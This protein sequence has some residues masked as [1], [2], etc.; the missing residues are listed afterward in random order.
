MKSPKPPDPYQTAQAQFGG[1]V[2]AAQTSSIMNNPDVYNFYGQQTWTPGAT[3]YVTG[4]NG[5]RI[6][7]TRQ[8]QRQTLSPAEQQ[9]AL[10]EQRARG[11]LSNTAAEQA[12]VLQKDLRNKIDPSK[13]VS[14]DKGPR[15]EEVR[16]DQGPTD[17]PAIEDAMMKL[18]HRQ[19]DP[20]AE[21]QMAQ[22][23]ARGA[24][25]GTPIANQAQQ[26]QNDAQTDAILKAYL[27]SGAEARAAQGAFNEAGA[28]RFNMGGQAADRTNA[29]RGMQAEQAFALDN[30]QI[31]KVMALLGGGTPNIPQFAGYQGQGVNAP[32]IAGLIANNYT[33]QSN[34]ANAFN[35]GLFGIGANLLGGAA[36]AGAFN[37]MFGG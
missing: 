21:A 2:G 17:R 8:V 24:G 25:A 16:Q 15:V 33:Q 19:A 3:Q 12:G 37:G 31:A 20:A 6:P 27:G 29:L 11:T 14:W 9:I 35:S 5:Q 13:W 10:A 18:Y 26:Q 1:E 34:A 23:T 32:N 30:Q 36:G 28:L 7:I 4:P 22:L